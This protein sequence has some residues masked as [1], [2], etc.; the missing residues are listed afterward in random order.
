ME[1][2]LASGLVGNHNAVVKLSPRAHLF[3]DLG[4]GSLLGTLLAAVVIDATRLD[5]SLVLNTVGG[6]HAL[7][8]IDYPRGLVG[9]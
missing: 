9:N 5:I 4:N 7:T 2:Y 3:D 1:L 8:G 6:A